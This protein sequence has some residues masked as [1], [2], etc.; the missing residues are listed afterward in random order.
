MSS[1]VSAAQTAANAVIEPDVTL[2]AMNG[3][4]NSLSAT[5]GVDG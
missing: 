5:A 2:T 4:Q 3:A 1:L